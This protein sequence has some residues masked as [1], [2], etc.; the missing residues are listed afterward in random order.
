MEELSEEI[1]N[2]REG[3][4][5]GSNLIVKKQKGL[6]GWSIVFKGESDLRLNWGEIVRGQIT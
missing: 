6:C 4:Q 1:F 2:Q 5:A 3:L